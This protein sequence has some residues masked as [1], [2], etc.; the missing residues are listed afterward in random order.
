MRR[1][2]CPAL[3]IGMWLRRALYCVKHK[4]LNSNTQK[5]NVKYKTKYNH[6]ITRS[7][8]PFKPNLHCILVC[9]VKYVTMKRIV[10]MLAF[11]W[12]GLYKLSQMHY[13]FTK[14]LGIQPYFERFLNLRVFWIFFSQ[15]DMKNENPESQNPYALQIGLSF[16]P[17]RKTSFTDKLWLALAM[18]D[19]G[20]EAITNPATHV[21]QVFSLATLCLVQSV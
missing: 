6:I 15:K 20:G 1:G 11:C 21:I 3:T 5:H 16:M 8:T 4:H 10:T 2:G 7:R 12:R 14:L 13:Q 17:V 19:E 18:H 9:C